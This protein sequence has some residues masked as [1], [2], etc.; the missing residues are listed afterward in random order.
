MVSQFYCKWPTYA[1]RIE[2]FYLQ[3]EQNFG[4]A[5]HCLELLPIFGGSLGVL[6]RPGQ[7]RVMRSR[8][9]DSNVRLVG[10]ETCEVV[11]LRPCRK[12]D[13]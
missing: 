10:F 6:A 4:N 11:Q 12:K 13:I 2:N 9:L 1:I 3:N 5:G 7:P 8:S